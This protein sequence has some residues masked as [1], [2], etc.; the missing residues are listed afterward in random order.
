MHRDLTG[1][2]FRREIQRRVEEIETG[3]VQGTDALAA[4]KK[5]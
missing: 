4:L 3:K 2:A 1:S 5:M